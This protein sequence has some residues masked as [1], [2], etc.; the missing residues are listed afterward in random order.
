MLKRLDFVVALSLVTIIVFG[1]ALY[2]EVLV[3]PEWMLWAGIIAAG[4]LVR[5]RVYH[6]EEVEEITLVMAMILLA[7]QS[8]GW[9]E[10]AIATIVGVGVGEAFRNRPWYKKVYNTLAIGTAGVVTEIVYTYSNIAA[11]QTIIGTAIL[12]DLLLYTFLVP[13]WLIVAKQTIWEIQESYW[14]T[15]YVV[16]VSA[17][18]AAGMLAS[19][20]F[21]GTAA[22]VLIAV[23]TVMFLKPR[24]VIQ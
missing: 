6:N 3:V 19:V 7:I 5:T 16:P 12:F 15:F 21:L 24:Y 22:I 10:I 11:M 9:P 20:H 2:N 23:G 1:I 8:I 17:V 13:I 18:I 14:T 4:N